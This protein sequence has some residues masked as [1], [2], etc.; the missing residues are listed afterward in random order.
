MAVLFQKVLLNGLLTIMCS[1]PK[2]ADPGRET[3]RMPLISCYTLRPHTLL[4]QYREVFH[5]PNHCRYIRIFL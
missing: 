1:E 3:N 2:G 4:D 5:V